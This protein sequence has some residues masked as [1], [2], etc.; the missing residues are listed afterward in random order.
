[1]HF[2]MLPRISFIKKGHRIILLVLLLV[3]QI[4]HVHLFILMYLEL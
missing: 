4:M 3:L 2:H 1:M